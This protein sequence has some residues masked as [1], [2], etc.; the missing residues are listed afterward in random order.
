M[1][2]K[3]NFLFFC[4][5]VVATGAS[6]QNPPLKKLSLLQQASPKTLAGIVFQKTKSLIQV[7][8]PGNGLPSI[9]ANFYSTNLGFFCKQEIK[10][11]KAIKIPFRFRLGS[12]ADCDRLE[13]KKSY[14]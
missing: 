5:I 3:A 4:M 14:R 13:G 6:A 11:D 1:N 7:S 9:A 2:R 10:M 8:V 12:V